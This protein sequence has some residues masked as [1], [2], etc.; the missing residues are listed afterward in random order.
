M[1]KYIFLIMGCFLLT[2]CDS[3]SQRIAE[4]QKYMDEVKRR[5]PQQVEPIP[6]FKVFKKFK[7]SANNTRNPFIPTR[8]K[9]AGTNM[10]DVNRPKEEL[11]SF[12]LDSLRM[13]GALSKGNQLWALI[14]AP[15]SAV[16][17]VSLGSH[18]GKNYGKVTKI[19]PNKI[20]LIETVPDNAGGWQTREA[21]I[22]LQEK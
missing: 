22:G 11:E 9:T 12:P 6:E 14:S 18:M 10:P 8:Q 5:A 20:V 16:Y 2:A 17:R 3:S 21:T 1:N 19:E 15:D 7:Y 13:V 4:Q